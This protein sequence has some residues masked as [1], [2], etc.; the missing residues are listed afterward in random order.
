MTRSIPTVIKS[1]L[2]SW[3]ITIPCFGVLALILTFTD[4]PDD[5]IAPAVTFV[6]I[7]SI[8]I[9]AVLGTSGKTSKGWLHGIAAGFFYI[10]TLYLFS[11][12]VFGNFSID[13]YTIITLAIGILT[14]ALGGITGINLKH[15]K[16]KS[17]I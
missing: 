4:F 11:S 5:L 7:I 15:H 10:F 16:I 3:I 17:K 12:I 13:G 9:A 6:T 2:I 1:I 8:F 14:G